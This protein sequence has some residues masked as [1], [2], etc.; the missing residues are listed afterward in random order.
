MKRKIKRIL[1]PIDFDDASI[2]AIT[3]S[4]NLAKVIDASLTI[5]NIR[6]VPIIEEML[7]VKARHLDFKQKEETLKSILQ[8]WCEEIREEH[9]I[10][11]GYTV[12]PS[13][14]NLN[15]TI[16]HYMDGSNYDLLVLGT[17]GK[18]DNYNLFFDKGGRQIIKHIRCHFLMVPEEWKYRSINS[19]VFA[20]DFVNQPQSIPFDLMRTFH[21]NMTLLQ[22]GEYHHEKPLFVVKKKHDLEPLQI[23][24]EVIRDWRTKDVIFNWLTKRKDDLLVLHSTNKKWMDNTFNMLLFNKQKHIAIPSMVYFTE[25]KFEKQEKVD[26]ES[27]Q[28]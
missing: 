11:C 18:D 6:E 2:N 24:Q 3:Y 8:D 13:W 5:W 16:D 12:R 23:N 4:A 27:L 1:C 9:N 28:L 17:N 26:K 14:M 19:I 20:S 25:S 10:A 21:S 7:S 22:L 15:Q